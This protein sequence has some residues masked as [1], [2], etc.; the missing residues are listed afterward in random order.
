[1]RPPTLVLEQETSTLQFDGIDFQKG[2]ETGGR[3]DT[4]SRNPTEQPIQ[5]QSFAKAYYTKYLTLVIITD[6]Y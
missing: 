4:A 2:A 3:P 5:N 6:S 1:M